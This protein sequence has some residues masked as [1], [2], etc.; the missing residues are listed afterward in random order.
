MSFH[1]QLNRR[2][3]SI[4][5]LDRVTRLRSY[6]FTSCTYMC[7]GFVQKS[8]FIYSR[9]I[10]GMVQRVCIWELKA[11]Q[12]PVCHNRSWQLSWSKTPTIPVVH[13][14][15]PANIYGTFC[16]GDEYM[17]ILVFP[18]PYR[19]VQFGGLIFWLIFPASF[20][21]VLKSFSAL[22]PRVPYLTP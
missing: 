11:V 17:W 22:T 9:K 10:P 8:G 4:T 19:W 2:C 12:C 5:G 7:S 16:P 13:L 18:T 20:L 14:S 1:H 21:L 3:K 6:C 15:L